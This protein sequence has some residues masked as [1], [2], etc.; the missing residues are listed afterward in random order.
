[1]GQLKFYDFAELGRYVYTI[2]SEESQIVMVVLLYDDAINFIKNIVT[3]G[4]V[5]I[6]GIDIDNDDY[7]WC[8]KEFYI[9]LNADL[10][11]DVTCNE[12]SDE[13]LD[14][15]PDFILYGKDITPNSLAQK[16]YK[17]EY[18]IVIENYNNLKCKNC[19]E[20]C[21]NCS[22]KEKCCNVYD[23]PYSI[24]CILNYLYEN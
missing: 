14:A 22:Y 17:D 20:D 23:M 4:D 13:D 2:A 3:Y 7:D 10:V 1:M 8:D 5:S 12:F 11:L 18:E 9:T 16:T 19:I 6:G 24:N 15:N 21:T